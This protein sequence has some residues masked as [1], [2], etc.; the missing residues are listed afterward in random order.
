MNNAELMPDSER[1][2]RQTL[3]EYQTILENAPVG[4][5]VTRDRA[6]LRFNERFAEMF[7]WETCDLI[8]QPTTVVYPSAQAYADLAS[9]AIPALAGGNRIDVELELTQRSGRRFWCRM[10]AKAIDPNDH[11]AGTVFITEDIT[12][13]R[14]AQQAL[15]QARDDLDRRV[16]ERTAELA[17]ANARLQEEIAE[18]RHAEEQ[19]LHLANHD[20]LTGLPN[21]RLLMDRLERAMSQ[22]RRS[23]DRLAILFIDLDCFKLIND[24]LGHGVGDRVL[25]AVATR[26]RTSLREVDTISRVG[27]DEFVLILPHMHSDTAAS[28]I[29]RKLMAS[30]DEPY[31]I[32]GELLCVTPSIGMSMFPKDGTDEETLISRADLAMYRAKQMGRRNLQVFSEGAASL[33]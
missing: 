26:L 10:L 3:L 13:R 15:I 21:R 1:A 5:A 11:G 19:I 6:F 30:L 33:Q 22:T 2:L 32:D 25:Q 20:A 9:I 17:L 16:Q 14:Y 31:L 12:E 27:G 28:E 8:G 18:R 23:G 24:R 29:A 7:G 4:V